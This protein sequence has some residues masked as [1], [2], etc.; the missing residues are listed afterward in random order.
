VAAGR[1]IVNGTFTH[2]S[3]VAALVYRG[4][5]EGGAITELVERLDGRSLFGRPLDNLDAPT[6]NE[7]ARRLG[8]SVVVGLDEDLPRLRALVDNPVFATRR[9]EPPFVLWMGP[10]A[11]LP[12]RVGRGRWQI[13]LATGTEAW[14]SAMLAYY[15]LWRATAGGTV[16]P[17]RRGSTG[18][19]E[20]RLPPGRTVVDLTYRPAVPE[21]TGLA[22]TALGL[23]IWLGVGWRR[24]LRT[25]R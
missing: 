18:Q 1:A 15:P 13:E 25:D 4:T 14:V 9:A 16:L 24:P 11:T 5:T 2:P 21:W 7:Y 3:P 12:Q 19:L 17:T 22:L 23:A 8:V 20:V 10:P 6:F